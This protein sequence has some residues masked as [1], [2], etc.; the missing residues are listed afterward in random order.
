MNI[1]IIIPTLNE[2]KALPIL[3]AELQQVINTLQQSKH[4]IQII[5]VDDGSD[6]GTREYLKEQI[7]K[8]TLPLKLIERKERGLATAVLRGFEETKAEILGVMD[9]D[10]SHPTKLITECLVKFPEYDL[11]LPSRNIPGGGAEEWPIHRKLTS[12]LATSLVHL[13]GIKA[14]DPMSGYFFLK[15]SVIENIS[16]SPIGYKILLE[17]LVKG[18]INKMIEIPYIFR[19]RTVGTSKMSSRIIFEYLKHLWYLW[20]WR[21]NNTIARL[22]RK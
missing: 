12:K 7:N 9:A 6:D 4:K 20:Q 10:L 11:V 13:I 14:K 22:W 18:K 5:I 15:R 2:R 17:I 3:L 21:Q 8:N 19:N 1:A 16:L